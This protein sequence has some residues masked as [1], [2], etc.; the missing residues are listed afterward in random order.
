MKRIVENFLILLIVLTL[1]LFA[2][3]LFLV[4]AILKIMDWVLIKLHLKKPH[5]REEKL[6]RI[7]YFKR[8]NVWPGPF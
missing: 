4:M 8:Y 7:E 6:S 5:S 1:F 2:M 3:P